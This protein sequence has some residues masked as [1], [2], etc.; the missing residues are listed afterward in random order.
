MI[1][2]LHGNFFYVAQQLVNN[3]VLPDVPLVLGTITLTTTQGVLTIQDSTLASF[4]PDGSGAGLL[5][6]MQGTGALTGASGRLRT[7]GVFQQGCVDCDYRG[8]VCVP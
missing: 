4:A 6:I 1:G 3:P 7:F 5:T 2:G 8:E